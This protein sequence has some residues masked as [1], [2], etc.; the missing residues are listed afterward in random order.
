VQ[1]L[2]KLE[3]VFA[4]FEE[5]GSEPLYIIMGSF[6]SRPVAR[7]LGGRETIQAA[8]DALAGVIGKFPRQAEKAK[9]LLVPGQWECSGG[10]YVLK[11][12]SFGRILD[13]K[14]FFLFPPGSRCLLMLML[15]CMSLIGPMDAGTSVALP[16]R[17]IPEQYTKSLRQRVKHI[18]F[19]SNPCRVRY[20]TQEIVLFREDLLK[21][22]QRHLA[23]PLV[24]DN[25]TAPDITEQLVESL[26]NQ[27]SLK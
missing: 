11:R 7:S 22:M 17:P 27:V 4:G 6:I 25:P 24:L 16:R 21:K 8:F 19:A 14:T 20:F 12:Q 23:V 3:A 15:C 18:T 10:K 2:E 5:N 9:F 13:S 1:V 26:L